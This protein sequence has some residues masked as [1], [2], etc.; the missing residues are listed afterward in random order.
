MRFSA[1]FVVGISQEFLTCSILDAILLRQ[2]LHR[3]AATKIAC[4]NRPL[5]GYLRYTGRKEL[6]TKKS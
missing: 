6:Q 4:V 3:V 2:K 1:R 5:D